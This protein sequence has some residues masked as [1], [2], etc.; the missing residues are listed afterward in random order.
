MR[1]TLLFYSL[2]LAALS[3]QAQPGAT[4]HASAAAEVAEYF[5]ESRWAFPKFEEA[6]IFLLQSR[7]KATMN[8]DLL[9]E[10]MMFIDPKGDTLAL[11]NSDVI[12]IQLGTRYF[13]PY[14]K[15]YLEVVERDKERELLL[16]RQIK[17]TDT[18]KAGAYGLPTST[19]AVSNV[20]TVEARG[21]YRDIEVN[22]WA[23]YSHIATFYLSVGSR[24]RAANRSG[25]QKAYAKHKKRVK[26]YLKENPVSFERS[27]DVVRLFN[28]CNS[29]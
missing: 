4:V 26:T 24:I 18:Q 3:A 11:T 14:N 16:R 21:Y 15:C 13:K 9:T 5:S 12:L 25:F 20:N 29:L 6:S 1:K 10:K 7:S 27:E 2:L 28:F 17:R 8:Y 23:K 22:E 19:S